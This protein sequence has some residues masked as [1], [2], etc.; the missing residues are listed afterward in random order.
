MKLRLSD[1]RLWRKDRWVL[2]H[3]I[4][5]QLWCDFD[6]RHVHDNTWFST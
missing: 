5:A 4:M 6:L 1:G 3:W 2:G